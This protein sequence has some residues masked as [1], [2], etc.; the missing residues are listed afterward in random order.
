MIMLM[1]DNK[2]MMGG[3]GRYAIRHMDFVSTNFKKWGF[4]VNLIQ[5][6]K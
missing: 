6:H 4:T 2:V 1:F 5:I 3:G